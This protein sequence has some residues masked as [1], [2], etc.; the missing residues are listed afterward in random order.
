MISPPGNLALVVGIISTRQGIRSTKRTAVI[1]FWVTFNFEDVMDNQVPFVK[2]DLEAR[3]KRLK[4]EVENLKR[5]IE[6]LRTLSE[7]V[8]DNMSQELSHRVFR[9]YR[10]LN[11]NP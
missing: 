2:I 9:L 7:L 10:T 5:K 3:V 8:P 1:V 6:D 4:S 11:G